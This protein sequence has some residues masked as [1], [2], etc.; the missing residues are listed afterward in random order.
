MPNQLFR[1][2]GVNKD[3]ENKSVLVDGT[4]INDATMRSGLKVAESVIP[5][6][7]VTKRPNAP[8]RAKRVNNG[9]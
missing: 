7:W 1:V 6:A 8:K 9:W 2:E 5:D 4:C 3:G